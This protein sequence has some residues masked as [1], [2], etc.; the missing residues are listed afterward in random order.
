[1]EA[2]TK[3]VHV[4]GKRK[5]AIARATARPGKGIVKINNIPLELWQPELAR[6]RIQE[7]LKIAG[8]LAA[9][10]NVDINVHGGGWSSQA[11]AARLAL[12]K[13]LV[14]YTNSEQLKK[15]FMAYDRALLV[16]DTRR[17]EPKKF[18]RHSRARARRQTSYR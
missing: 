15:M 11:E 4:A 6:L 7:P 14:A 3:V 1:M 9:E 16:A 8:Q 5:E 2:K 18:G 17:K 12:A 13:S 10:V